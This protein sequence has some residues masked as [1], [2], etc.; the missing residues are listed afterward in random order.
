MEET[1]RYADECLNVCRRSAFSRGNDWKPVTKDE[2]SAFFG[3]VF[4]MGTVRKPTYSSYWET[5]SGDLITETPNFSQV[6]Y[7]TRFNSILRFHHCID[8]NLTVLRVR[9][10]FDP[11]HKVRPIIDF[12]QKVK[13]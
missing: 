5:G 7:R 12:F 6:M 4:A 3:L 10:G 9:P 2:M 8:N 13:Y 11:L 1:N